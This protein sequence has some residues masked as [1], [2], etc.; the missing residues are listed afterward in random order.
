VASRWWQ[1]ALVL[2][3]PMALRWGEPDVLAALP[4]PVR[5]TGDPGR[6]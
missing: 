4:G 2:D 6:L 5:H 1:A 3:Y